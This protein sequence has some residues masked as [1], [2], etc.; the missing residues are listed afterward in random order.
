MNQGNTRKKVYLKLDAVEF[1][2]AGP[3]ASL[4]QALEELPHGLVVQSVGTVENYTLQHMEK[5][6]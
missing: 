5:E 4:G 2:E 1:I 3:S 6:I